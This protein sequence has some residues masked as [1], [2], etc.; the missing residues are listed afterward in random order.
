VIPLYG[1]LAGDTIGLLVLASAQD[2]AADLAAKLQSAA[3]VRVRPF[4][5]PVVMYG[6]RRLPPAATVA[7]CN[8][9]ALHRFDVVA[10][11]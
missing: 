10:G 8:I 9:R 7:E 11:S 6:G 5:N 3:A 2:T 1:F 4:L